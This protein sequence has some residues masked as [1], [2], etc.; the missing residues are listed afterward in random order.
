MSLSFAGWNFFLSQV[1]LVIFEVVA[2]G[3][4]LAFWEDAANINPAITITAVIVAYAFLNLWDARVSCVPP[5]SRGKE[6][7]AD[8][9]LC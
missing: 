4:V 9:F 3:L 5:A 7:R 1:A 6:R 2:F 8:S